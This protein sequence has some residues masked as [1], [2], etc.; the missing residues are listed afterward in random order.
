MAAWFPLG[1]RGL[2]GWGLRQAL[3]MGLIRSRVL[4]DSAQSCPVLG[5]CFSADLQERPGV[6]AADGDSVEISAPGAAQDELMQ[7]AQLC[8]KRV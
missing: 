6:C 2:E 5:R 4:E 3:V 1:G 7:W 8:V